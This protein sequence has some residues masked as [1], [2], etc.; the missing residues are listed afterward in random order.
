MI[1]RNKWEVTVSLGKREE[2]SLQIQERMEG[3]TLLW[4]LIQKES[5][6]KLEKLR[7]HLES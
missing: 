6:F 4:L 7:E 2:P 3:W 1:K 5:T